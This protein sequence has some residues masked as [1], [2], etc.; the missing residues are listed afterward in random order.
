MKIVFDAVHFTDAHIIR[1]H[2]RLARYLA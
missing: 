1:E 2:P